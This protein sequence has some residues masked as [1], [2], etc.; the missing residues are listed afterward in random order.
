M[1]LPTDHVEQLNWQVFEGLV[2]QIR[3]HLCSMDT[4]QADYHQLY[5]IKLKSLC[6]IMSFK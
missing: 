4:I 1:Q 2:G 6:I 3:L 5:T